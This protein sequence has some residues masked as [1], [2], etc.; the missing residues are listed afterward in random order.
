[1]KH[2]V[3]G[4]EGYIGQKLVSDLIN[5]NND[6]VISYDCIIYKQKKNSN[7]TN[8]KLYRLIND[9]MSNFKKYSKILTSVDSIIIL[10][11]LVGDPITKKYSKIS[12][13][14]NEN[15]IMNIMKMASKYKVSKSIFVSTCSN[16]GLVNE[17]EFATERHKLKPL[18][19]Y[20]KSKVKCE[21]Y[22]FKLKSNS[23]VILRFATA[24]GLSDRMRFDLTVN[25]FTRDLFYK[26]KL[27]I[28]DQKSWSP[29]CHVSDFSRII[30]KVLETKKSKVAYQI[31]NVGSNNNNCTKKDLVN[32][33]IKI[34]KYKKN[35]INYLNKGFDKR[36][37]KVDFS[38]IEKVLKIKTKFDINY[39]IKEI[40]SCFKKNKNLFKNKKLGN[41]KI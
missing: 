34:L 12:K 2:L 35:N 31:F 20:S 1:M 32:K 8:K 3:V 18:S 5:I 36:N 39:G 25:E 13:K 26:K 16:Y 27:D 37:Y 33:I 40:L 9:S 7:F 30:R 10:A 38:K 41:Y 11:G 4:G 23:P 28:Y 22:F 21:K 29:Y 15:N 6:E 17:N 14:I 19:L 24:F